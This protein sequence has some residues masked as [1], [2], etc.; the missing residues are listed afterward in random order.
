M[1]LCTVSLAQNFPQDE[2]VTYLPS[3]GNIADY[4]VDMYSGYVKSDQL[5]Y[6][7]LHYTLV[8]PT[9]NY[10]DLPLVIWF[11][12]GLGCSSMVG[13]FTENGPFYLDE[14]SNQFYSNNA[15]WTKQANVLYFESSPTTGYSSCM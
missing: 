13:L 12:N 6:H 2:Q 15:S 7:R 1:T 9:G 8:I 3:I 10:Q 5:G 14:N 4:N 11:N